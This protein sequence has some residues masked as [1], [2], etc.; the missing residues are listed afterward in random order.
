MALVAILA[1]TRLSLWMN[2]LAPDEV[3]AVAERLSPC[4]ARCESDED[5]TEDASEVRDVVADIDDDEEADK[6]TV[7]STTSSLTVFKVSSSFLA[8]SRSRSRS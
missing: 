7:S 2:P 3:L 8:L 5:E 1:G 4:E 6:W